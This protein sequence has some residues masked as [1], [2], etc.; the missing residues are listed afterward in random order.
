MRLITK[1]EII[2]SRITEVHAT[3]ED[4]NGCDC[5]TIFFTVDRGFS[6]AL[7]EPGHP[8]KTAELPPSAERLSDQSS[9]ESYKVEG[10]WP[11]MQFIPESS[12]VVDIIKRIKQRRIAGVFCQKMDQD[13]GFY[14]PDA[15]LLLFDDGSQAFC[16]T[17][18]PHGTGGTGLFY[19]TVDDLLKL[20]D[21]VDFFQVPLEPDDGQNEAGA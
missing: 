13:L 20:D 15:S 10:S 12:S 2:G 11:S 8:W 14:E 7:P 6:F 3:F 19:R 18:A 5:S 1:F 21:L 4:L 17:V 9:S 16:V